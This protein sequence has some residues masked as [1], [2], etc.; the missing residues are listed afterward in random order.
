MSNFDSIFFAT[1]ALCGIAVVQTTLEYFSI[2]R[3]FEP[4]GLFAWRIISTRG[5]P[6]KT[7]FLNSLRDS[8]AGTNM[9]LVLLARGVA[10]IL[11]LLPGLSDSWVAI[12]AVV[13]VMTGILT[14]YRTVLGG[15]G[16]DQMMVIVLAGIIGISII[17]ETSIIR[18]AGLWFVA[19]QAALSYFTA[20]FAKLFSSQW[21]EGQAVGA[22][23]CSASYGRPS[24]GKVVLRYRTLGMMLCWSVVLFE[25]AFPAALF[26]PWPYL[27][28]FMIAGASFHLGTAL[29]MGLNTFLWAFLATYPAIYACNAW[30]SSFLN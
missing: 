27:W 24:I 16:S 23:L 18:N 4:S 1:R 14:S 9:T 17:P 7:S 20:G 10:G 13:S 21:R 30:I 26:L 25:V 6:F 22:I 29:L 5:K 3:E 8:I 11:L 19:G 28:G 2:R 15:D 12:A